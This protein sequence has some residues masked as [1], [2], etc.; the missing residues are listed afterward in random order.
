MGSAFDNLAHNNIVDECFFFVFLFVF[1]LMSHHQ[2]YED[3][4]EKMMMPFQ[5]TYNVYY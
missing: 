2:P 4:G 3:G 1:L 5:T